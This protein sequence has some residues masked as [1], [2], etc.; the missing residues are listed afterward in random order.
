MPQLIVRGSVVTVATEH[1]SST[2]LPS[3]AVRNTA[4][5]VQKT[6]K[7]KVFYVLVYR[8]SAETIHEREREGGMLEV[9]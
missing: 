1:S 2:M 5:N 8:P 4:T 7:K 3:R 6:F 9:G